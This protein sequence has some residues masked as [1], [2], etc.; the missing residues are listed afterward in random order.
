[1]PS[2]ASSAPPS[3][4]DED[5]TDLRA[6]LAVD[7]KPRVV[8][9]VASAA[10][11]AGTRGNVIRLGDP[12]ESE[13]IVVRLGRDEVPF[14]PTELGIPGRKGAPVAPAAKA[15]PAGREPKAPRAPRAPR[16]SAAK[17][18]P[19]AKRVMPMTV[20]MRFKDGGWTVEAQRGAKRLAKPAA[21]RPGAVSAFAE[22]L[23]DDA[24]RAA[25]TETVEACRA[26]IEQQATEL[27]ALLAETEMS[28]R[29]YESRP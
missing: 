9:L 20:I 13:Y 22:H 18:A 24:V 12:A 4:T 21:L 2:R 17:T 26:V 7:E 8:V 23:E 3:L 5:L 6:K 10:V 11:P 1:V 14:A 25:L 19:P 28:L 27:R 16:A 29:D 15:A